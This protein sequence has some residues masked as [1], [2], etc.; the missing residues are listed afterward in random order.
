MKTWE[1]TDPSIDEPSWPVKEMHSSKEQ[2]N[3]SEIA[4]DRQA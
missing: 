4:A 2:E 1:E 3:N